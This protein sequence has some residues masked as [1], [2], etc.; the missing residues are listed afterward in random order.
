MSP[1]V[2]DNQEHRTVRPVQQRN[3]LY[4]RPERLL[5]VN[6]PFDPI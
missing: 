3:N 1:G 6:P 4:L 2:M 5:S